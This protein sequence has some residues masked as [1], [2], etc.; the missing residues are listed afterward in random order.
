[1]PQSYVIR[2]YAACA[3]DDYSSLGRRG[4]WN[5]AQALIEMGLLVDSNGGVDFEPDFF[6]QFLIGIDFCQ[7][8]AFPSR[9]DRF[10]LGR[11]LSFGCAQL[12]AQTCLIDI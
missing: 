8:L 2:E 12:I 9:I 1:M 10:T 3:R 6:F 11:C 4:I 5:Q 7:E